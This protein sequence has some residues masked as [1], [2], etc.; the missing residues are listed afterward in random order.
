MQQPTDGSAPIRAALF[1]F[2]GTISILRCGWE[3]VMA[4]LFLEVLQPLGYAPPEDIKAQVAAYIDQSTG[5]QTIF[6]M[7]WLAE[8]VTRHGGQA[9]DPW[10]YKEEYNRRLMLR[11]EEKKQLLLSG[12]HNRDRYLVA[13]AVAFLEFLREKGVRI[14]VASGT[15]HPDVVAEAGALGVARYFDTIMGAPPHE[16]NCSKEVVLNRLIAQ[17]AGDGARIAVIGDGKVEIALGKKIGAV[18]IGIA[19]D[20]RTG[21][22]ENPAK[23]ARLKQAGADIIIGDFTQ[24]DKALPLL[25]FTQPPQDRQEAQDGVPC[26]GFGPCQ[27]Q[28]RVCP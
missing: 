9:Q 17:H 5:I 20:E 26:A 22:G 1:D 27:N 15:D 21:H 25:G 23:T 16:E 11:V 7:K 4:P 12:M 24:I 14:D 6:Q 2:D 3:E 10:A 18:T 19:S 28:H 13:G 8:E